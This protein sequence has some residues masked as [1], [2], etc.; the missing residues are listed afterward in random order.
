ML[1]FEDLIPSVLMFLRAEWCATTCHISTASHLM[2]RMKLTREYKEK[3]GSLQM[4]KKNELEQERRINIFSRTH[5]LMASRI[6]L[7]ECTCTVSILARKWF[8]TFALLLS[9]ILCNFM[10]L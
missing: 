9:E 2:I 7:G 5:F 4:Q 3:H 8:G 10:N 6:V 1:S